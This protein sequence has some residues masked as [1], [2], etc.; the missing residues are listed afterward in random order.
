MSNKMSIHKCHMCGKKLSAHEAEIGITYLCTTH[1][2]E[3][4]NNENEAIANYS[5]SGV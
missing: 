2:N 3:A 4:E 5:P 1:A